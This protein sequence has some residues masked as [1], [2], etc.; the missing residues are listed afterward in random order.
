MGLENRKSKIGLALGGGAAKGLAHIGVL[1]V[2]EKE[3]VQIDMVAGTSIGS[4]IG[5][6]FAQGKNSKDMRAIIKD[7]DWKRRMSLVDL[8][9]PKSGFIAGKKVSDFLKTIIGDVSFDD[10]KMPF[11]CVATDIN[12]GEEIVINKGSV[13]EAVRA[14][15]SLPVIFAIVKKRGRYLV[16]G[17]LVDPVPVGVLKEM[18]ADFI[19]AVNVLTRMDRTRKR[20]YIEDAPPIEISQEREP[21]LFNILLKTTG[22]PATEVIEDSLK[23]AD[24]VIEPRVGG[25]GQAEFHRADEGILAGGLA[26]IDAMHVINRKL[27]ILP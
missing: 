26:A 14:S 21:R 15:I 3:K 13:L 2:L 5:A 20:I 19:I 9:L 24:V 27:A 25:I 22:I 10:L 8:A 23:G 18:G 16:D 6:L 7:W 11:A 4:I 1:E 12:S 17:G